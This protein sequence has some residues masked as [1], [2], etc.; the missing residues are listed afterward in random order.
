MKWKHTAKKKQVKVPSVH[1]SISLMIAQF[2]LAVREEELMHAREKEL[3]QFRDKEMKYLREKEL[4]HAREKELMHPREEQLMHAREKELTN[5]KT[6]THPQSSSQPMSQMKAD[7]PVRR[8]WYI[9]LFVCGHASTGQETREQ[10][11]GRAGNGFL[12]RLRRIF[13]R[14]K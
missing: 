1:E 2:E 4:M 13:R 7:T 5:Q 9:R 6:H 10:K 14:I 11:N 3:K 12:R 8:P